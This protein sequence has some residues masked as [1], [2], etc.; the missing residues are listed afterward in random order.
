MFLCLLLPLRILSF[1]LPARCDSVVL[2]WVII[3]CSWTSCGPLSASDYWNNARWKVL[4]YVH[5]QMDTVSHCS[6]LLV[7]GEWQLGGGGVCPPLLPAVGNLLD[8]SVSGFI[9]GRQRNLWPL[10]TGPKHA[11]VFLLCSAPLRFPVYTVREPP[12]RA[13]GSSQHHGPAF[14]T[15]GYTQSSRLYSAL[16]AF[17][18]EVSVDIYKHQDG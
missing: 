16:L 5:L 15:T 4:W 14:S 2:E 1:I 18:P 17:K 13:E 9:S 11:V 8:L 12:I 6:W 7:Q 3:T 10:R